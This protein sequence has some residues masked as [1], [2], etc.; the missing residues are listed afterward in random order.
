MKLLS[1]NLYNGRARSDSL[2]ELIDAVRPDVLVAQEV[3]LDAAGVIR[4]RFAH[5]AVEGA[6]DNTGRAL[7]AGAPIRVE[8]LPLALRDGYRGMTELDGDPLEIVVVHLANPVDGISALR[9]RRRQVGEIESAI[10]GLDRC[11]VVGD[12]NATPMWPAHRRL[13]RSL[14][15]LVDGWAD[16]AGTSPPRTWGPTPRSPAVLRIDHVLG[17]GVEVIDH[18]VHRI[19]GCDHRAVEVELR[20]SPAG[21]TA[22]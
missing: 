13:R 5:G 3:G 17:R 20:R 16:A 9:L 4:E 14:V 19:D 1:A 22:R 12:L 6:D 21:G 2:I 18:R 15:D 11:L 10:A 7:V 8:S